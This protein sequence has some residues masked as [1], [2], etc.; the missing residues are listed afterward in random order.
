MVLDLF[1][2]G[3]PAPLLGPSPPGDS[4][5]HSFLGSTLW[6]AH[7]VSQPT[8][9]GG[10]ACGLKTFGHFVLISNFLFLWDSSHAHSEDESKCRELSQVLGSVPA[11]T[12]C[13]SGPVLGS[14]NQGGARHG[15]LRVQSPL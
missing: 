3:T 6:A 7:S 12:Y 15:P 8:T 2:M 10:R 1:R 9:D 14:G 4:H 11:S 13:R 5:T